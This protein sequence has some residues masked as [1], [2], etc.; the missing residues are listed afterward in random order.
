MRAIVLSVVLVASPALAQQVSAPATVPQVAAP[1]VSAPVPSADAP[2]STAAPSPPAQAAAPGMDSAQ[3]PQ[4][5]D[6]LG[7]LISQS[8]QTTDEEEAETANK[9][10]PKHRAT[11]LP[12]PPRESE[13]SAVPQGGSVTAEKVYEMRVR[14]SIAAAQ[15]LQGPLDG[16]WRVT[17]PDGAQI[18]A[19]QIVD[20]AGGSGELEGAWRDVRRPGTVGSTGLIEDLRHDGGEVVIRFSPKGGQSSVLTLR[21]AG[22]TRWSGE[23]AENGASQPIVAEHVL[24]QAPLGYESQGRGPYVWPPR[25]AAVSRPAPAAAPACS[26][27]GK[28]GKALK[29]A[30]AKCAAAAKKGK[31]SSLKKGKGGKAKA[32]A[33]RK[34]K[35]TAKKGSTKKKR[36]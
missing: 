35:A 2:V 17:G 24:P 26:T 36:R 10:A 19:L 7:D 15:N 12:I 28:K 21:Q 8:N 11:I 3:I 20:K 27:K 13:D 23:L 4:A 9:P 18:Y 22:E 33:S 30:K 34:G 1:P 31:A 6:P 25:V 16:G 14:G 29:A 5:I 32:T